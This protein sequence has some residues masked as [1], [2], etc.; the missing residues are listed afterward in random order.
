MLRSIYFAA[1]LGVAF[2]PPAIAQNRPSRQVQLIQLGSEPTVPEAEPAAATQEVAPEPPAL[3]QAMLNAFRV[4]DLSRQYVEFQMAQG[5][6]G[7]GPARL[8]QPAA[9]PRV[10]PISSIQVPAWMRA[11]PVYPSIRYNGRCEPIPYAPSGLL[12]YA[13]EARRASYYSMMSAIACEHGIPVG[14]FDAVIMQE[15][16]YNPL[17][18]SSAKAY[19]L[20]QLMP[21]TA[22]GLGVDRY[23]VVQN[24]RGGARY[25]RQQLDRYG[26][27]HLALAA[28]N[29]GPGRVKASVPRINETQKY[30][31][32]IIDKWSS[33]ATG[34]VLQASTMGRRPVRR[35]AGVLSF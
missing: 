6:G 20:A 9:L 15:S 23:D 31:A 7:T 8:P 34:P 25:L 28:Y 29:A 2:G 33:L 27:V 21:G 1:A 19:G 11:A 10:A 30:V 22:A 4:H 5:F 17:A 14:L 18:V 24:L 16:R 3:T 12:G 13:A 26:Q 35:E 32:S